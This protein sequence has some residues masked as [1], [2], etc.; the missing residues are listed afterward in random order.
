MSQDKNSPNK[1]RPPPNQMSPS[2]DNTSSPYLVNFE[3]MN[4]GY[5]PIYL[6]SH[7]AREVHYNSLKKSSKPKK[8][9]LLTP[10]FFVNPKNLNSPSFFLKKAQIILQ[11]KDNFF[12]DG[13][14][15][16]E[17]DFLGSVNIQSKVKLIRILK[18][19]VPEVYRR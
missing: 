3:S 18:D 6:D 1:Q 2:F 17:I 19:M 14:R 12:K 9:D 11:K 8:K 10:H 13:D 16:E 5:N 4:E 7:P 15:L